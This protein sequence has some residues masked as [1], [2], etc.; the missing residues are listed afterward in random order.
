MNEIRPNPRGAGRPSFEKSDGHATEAFRRESSRIVLSREAPSSLWLQLS[1][2][3]ENLILSGK[4]APNS[5]IPSEPALCTIFNVS[6]PVVRSA[7]GALAA[8]GLVVKLPRKGMFIGN[9]PRESGFVTANVSLFDDMVARGASIRTRTFELTKAK[10]DDEERAALQ[11]ADAAEVVRV[12][13]VFWVDDRPITYTHISFPASKVP[14]F[15]KQDVGGRSILGMI[16]DL[17]GRRLIRAER[18]FTAT[19]PSALAQ[20]RMGVP[21]DEP[22]IWIESIGFENDGSPLEYYRAY[23][24]SKAARIHVSVSN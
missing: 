16:R 5:R 11:L 22:L 19:M 14:G 7:I 23:Y 1:D 8:R 3:L 13:R 18:W 10:A 15:E 2:Q 20:E 9:P 24:N 17:Y 21:G 4:L 12:T 6:R